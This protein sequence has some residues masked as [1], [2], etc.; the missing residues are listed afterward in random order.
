MTYLQLIFSLLAACLLNVCLITTNALI[1]D[2]TLQ[3]FD[4]YISEWSANG[5]LVEFYSPWCG[6]CIHFSPT[7]DKV[8][9]QIQST[10][11]IK[12]A[13]VDITQNSALGKRYRVMGVP[14]LI[15]FIG[16]SSYVYPFSNGRKP[17]DIVNYVVDGYKQTSVKEDPVLKSHGNIRKGKL[18]DSPDF[19]ALMRK[20][21]D[22]VGKI[23]KKHALEPLVD[24][25][26]E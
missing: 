18:K 5:T 7:Y 14:T 15:F 20:I 10:T 21:H 9:Q 22:R 3:S 12:V 19:N 8:A 13:R 26:T 23:R 4:G 2:L 17:V 25:G 1:D 6:A 24:G 11:K 16:G